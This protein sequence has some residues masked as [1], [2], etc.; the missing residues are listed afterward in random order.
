[1]T[2]P[3]TIDTSGSGQRATAT[4]LAVA[5]LV[6]GLLALVTPFVRGGNPVSR[7]GGLLAFAAAIEMLH[8][9]RQSTA[10]RRRAT[11]SAVISMII[12]LF[13]L[14]ANFVM[15]HVLRA[16][17]AGWFAVDAVRYAA[18]ILRGERGQRSISTISALGD[19][20]VVL[21]LLFARGWVLTWV[22][23]IAGALRIFGIAWNIM[24]A[25]VYTTAEAEETVVSEL[26]LADDPRAAVIAAEVEAEQRAR[27]P[28]DRGWTLAFVATLFAIHVGRMSTDWTILGLMS[29]AVAVLGDMLIA[30]LIT[31]LVINPLYL[32]WR[33]PTRWIERRLWRWHLGQLET[34]RASW[35]RRA[36]DTWLRWRLRF[37][38][39]MRGARYSIPVALNRGLQT[40]LPFAAI[41]AATVP[42]WGMS[43]YFDTE[44]WAAGMW[45]SWAESRTDTWREAMVRAVLA[46]E[47]NRAPL[48][49]FAVAPQGVTSDD[50]SFVVIGDP[51]EGDASQHVLRDR[52]LSVANEPDVR[53]V[54]V[55]SDVVYPTG[56]MKDYE[57]KF[58]LPFKGV[59]RPVYAIPGNHD[60]YDALEAFAATFLQADAARASIRARVE[61]DL[62][63]TSTTDDRIEQLIQEAERLRVAYGVPTGFQRAPFFEVQTDRFALV[64]VDTGILRKID[65]AQAAWLEAALDR[66]SGKLTMAI[67]GHPF[68]AGGYDVTQGDEEFARLKQHLLDRGVRIVMAGDTHDLEYYVEP[69]SSTGAAVHHFVNGG[70][71]AYL[72]FGTSLAWPSR[73]P[74]ADWAFYPNR[75]AVMDKIRVRTPWW[76]RPAWWWTQEFGAWPFTAEWLSAAFDYNVAPFFQSFVEV[77]VEPSANRVRVI[78]YGVHGRLTWGELG[79]SASLRTPGVT[80]R[81]PIEWIVPMTPAATA[82]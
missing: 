8:A 62:R 44:N 43:W 50:F 34:A 71:G 77:K 41:V 66:A 79:A 17:V 35:L 56:A 63:M 18:D 30:V 33:K 55:S 48:S 6:L 29:P 27:V 69:G 2:L 15:G 75:D 45:N 61:T 25:P 3:Q 68:F 16:L 24:A 59:G 42:I 11:V 78:P 58:W 9:L 74:T 37:A 14:N 81:A 36:A 52:L 23:V 10:A 5:T 80:D 47:D 38:I 82:R 64:A 12:A 31:L 49:S 39:Q 46:R 26:G 40:G 4:S 13:L 73:A 51:G 67:L 70:G 54:V 20:A 1:V 65:A 53:F 32:L 28:I 57:A 72:S 19:V 21:L 60:W 22:V 7:V 76:K